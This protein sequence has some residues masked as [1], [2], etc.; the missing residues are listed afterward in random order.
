MA[1]VAVPR[2][3]VLRASMVG[4]NRNRTISHGFS[5]DAKNKQ[6]RIKIQVGG[7]VAGKGE[8]STTG[9]AVGRLNG[10]CTDP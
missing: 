6:S 4:M 9:K 5:A 2:Q 10:H 3:H 8:Y 1:G 7:G